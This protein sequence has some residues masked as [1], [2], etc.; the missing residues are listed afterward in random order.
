MS[1]AFFDKFIADLVKGAEV[2]SRS[3]GGP[4]VN[5]VIDRE[6]HGREEKV[7][8]QGGVGG[9]LGGKDDRSAFDRLRGKQSALEQRFADGAAAATRA[10]GLKEA[11]LGALAPIAGSILGGAGLRAGAGALAR[12]AGG[13]MLG[14]LATKALPHM[15]GGIGGAATDMIGSMAGGALGQH[16]MPQP[17][18]PQ[19]QQPMM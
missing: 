6:N 4:G 19:P 10:F 13:K 18:Q 5:I 11:F 9:H 15:T 14:S 1:D 2:N 8:N 12:G 17:R 16:M 7:A 3:V